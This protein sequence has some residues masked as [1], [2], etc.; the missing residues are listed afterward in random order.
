MLQ[1]FIIINVTV[2][3]IQAREDVLHEERPRAGLVRAFDEACAGRGVSG[4]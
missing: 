1:D 3:C 2:I 4:L